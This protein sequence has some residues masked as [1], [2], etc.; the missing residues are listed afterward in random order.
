MADHTRELY[1]QE[2]PDLPALSRTAPFASQSVLPELAETIEPDR[3]RRVMPAERS[4][5][6]DLPNVIPITDAELSAIERVSELLD[7]EL[8]GQA[9]MRTGISTDRTT[10]P[11]TPALR[12]MPTDP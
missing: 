2:K 7:G 6:D 4:V 1:A 3:S 11:G 8:E 12:Q 5:V 10:A 9:S